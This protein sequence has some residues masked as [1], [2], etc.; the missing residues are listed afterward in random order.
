MVSTPRANVLRLPDLDLREARRAAFFAAAEGRMST[1]MSAKC[2]R[3]LCQDAVEE[4]RSGEGGGEHHRR[5]RSQSLGSSCERSSLGGNSNHSSSLLLHGGGGSNHSLGYLSRGEAQPYGG[6]ARYP[7]R[8]GLMN[9]SGDVGGFETTDREGKEELELGKNGNGGGRGG[10]Y[11]STTAGSDV[12]ARQQQSPND[13]MAGAGGADDPVEPSPETSSRAAPPPP[14]RADPHPIPPSTP[15]DRSRGSGGR[16][17][18][19]IIDDPLLRDLRRE[20]ASQ[21]NPPMVSLLYGMI[22][23]SIVLPIVMSFGSIIYRD[24]FFRPYLSGLI[25]LTIV[26]GA[27]HQISFSTFSTLPFAVGSVQDAGERTGLFSPGCHIYIGCSR[28]VI[29]VPIFMFA[30]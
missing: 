23:T 5:S 2:T 25:Q 19:E 10:V 24:D 18:A 4:M 14:P 6:R 13:G 16:R 29:F 1:I 17:T 8:L 15:P 21:S 12:H 11:G 30:P 22:N 28:A 26:S 9:L 7:S 27:V 20:F 3:E